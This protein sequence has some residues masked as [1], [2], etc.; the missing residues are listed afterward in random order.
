MKLPKGLNDHLTSF[1]LSRHRVEWSGKLP[2][3]DMLRPPKFLGSGKCIL[4]SRVRFFTDHG[5]I[6][7]RADLNAVISIGNNTV[8]NGRNWFRATKRITIGNNVLIG[9]GVDIFDSDMHV[10]TPYDPGGSSPIV[11]EDNCWITSNSTILKGVCIGK[12]SVVGTRSVVAE[13]IPT[14]HLYVGTPV[15]FKMKEFKCPDGWIRP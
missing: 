8:M 3:M 12:H 11:I 4:G 9:P 14:K 5:P 15:H 2:E 1:Y 13:N 7:I 10:V 6:I